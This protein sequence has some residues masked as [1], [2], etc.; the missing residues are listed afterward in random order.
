MQSKRSTRVVEVTSFINVMGRG[1]VKSKYRNEDPGAAGV[2]A[3][4]GV[5]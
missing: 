1:M 2:D 5:V 3:V 4:R